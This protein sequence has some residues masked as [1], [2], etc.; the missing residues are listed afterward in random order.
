[1]VY[2]RSGSI[3][4]GGTNR[5]TTSSIQMNHETAQNAHKTGHFNAHIES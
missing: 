2:E 5:K 3:V 4:N 1:M